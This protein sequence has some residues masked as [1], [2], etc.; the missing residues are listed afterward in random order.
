[1]RKMHLR[2]GGNRPQT[3]LMSKARGGP[4]S[5]VDL[6]FCG[7]W[8]GFLRADIY[9]YIYICIYLYVNLAVERRKT[10]LLTV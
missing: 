1:M 2:G 4:N 8:C 6:L 9:I 5:N 7:I 3:T 10:V